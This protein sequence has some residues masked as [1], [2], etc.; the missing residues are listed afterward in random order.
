M[1]D[2]RMIRPVGHRSETPTL[3]P[4]VLLIEASDATTFQT[5]INTTIR[6]ML[7]GP[8]PMNVIAIGIHPPIMTDVADDLQTIRYLYSAA[9]TY[10]ST[11][12]FVDPTTRKDA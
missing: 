12:P 1:T 8:N 5:R 2:L 10:Q 4:H 7:D 9:I 6:A 3:Y 11:K